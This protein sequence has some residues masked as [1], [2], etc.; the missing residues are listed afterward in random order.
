M[1]TEEESSKYR[2]Y[3]HKKGPFCESCYRMYRSEVAP[4]VNEILGL[5]RPRAECLYFPNF[6]SEYAERPFLH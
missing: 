6:Q 5:E 1:L 4:R 2:E 3:F